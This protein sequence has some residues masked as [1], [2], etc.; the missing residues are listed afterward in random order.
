[1]YPNALLALYL[2]L[3]L[4]FAPKLQAIPHDV[5][6]L[7]RFDIREVDVAIP[8]QPISTHKCRSEAYPDE[9]CSNNDNDDNNDN[10]NNDDNDTTSDDEPNGPV[11]FTPSTTTAKPT[12]INGHDLHP[13]NPSTAVPSIV[14]RHDLNRYEKVTAIKNVCEDYTHQTGR[15]KVKLKFFADTDGD[16]DKERFKVKYKV[17]SLRGPKLK[18]KGDID[19]DGVKEKCDEEGCENSDSPDDSDRD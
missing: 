14:M 1:M 13:P 7:Q 3:T 2:H 15:D 9:Q 19:G 12:M 11:T 8:V 4:I 17:W 16:G 10:D 5:Q 6:V 18:I